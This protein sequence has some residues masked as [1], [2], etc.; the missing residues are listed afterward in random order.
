MS[1]EATAGPSTL[2]PLASLGRAAREPAS[3]AAGR[4]VSVQDCGAAFIIQPSAA[5]INNKMKTIFEDTLR[6]S[7]VKTGQFDRGRRRLTSEESGRKERH[8]RLAGRTRREHRDLPHRKGE[9][10]LLLDREEH[11]R[12]RRR[13]GPLQLGQQRGRQPLR[14]L[15]VCHV[16]ENLRMQAVRQR[17]DVRAAKTGWCT[18]RSAASS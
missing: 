2:G 17:Q 5:T 4:V 18:F 15:R 16:R 10:L 11:P 13:E 6:I 8:L 3:A 1:P 9:S 12:R 7:E 14:Q